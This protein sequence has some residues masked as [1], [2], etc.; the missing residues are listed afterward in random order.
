MAKPSMIC[1]LVV[2]TFKI[3]NQLFVLSHVLNR[4]QYLGIMLP[5]SDYGQVFYLL[6]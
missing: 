2:D 6:L 1:E 5:L 3:E 4:P